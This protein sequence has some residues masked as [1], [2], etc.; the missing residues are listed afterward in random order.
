MNPAAALR[1]TPLALTAASIA[2]FALVAWRLDPELVRGG[3]RP[4]PLG[5]PDRSAVEGTVRAFQR[6]WED[7]FASGGIPTL[8]DELPGSPEVRHQIFRDLG[9]LSDEGLVLVQDLA[10]LQVRALERTGPRTAEA[11]VAEEWNFTYQRAAD[12]KPLTKVRGLSV[13]MRYSLEKRRDGVWWVTG[14]KS[15]P[16]AASIPSREFTW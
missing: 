4:E 11:V 13:G 3:P 1:R 10:S 16:S 7:L 5:E 12:R 14:W 8:I 9:F 15:E 6:Y 2:A